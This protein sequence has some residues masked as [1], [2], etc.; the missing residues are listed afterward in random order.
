MARSS[1]GRPTDRPYLHIP[2]PGLTRQSSTLSHLPCTRTRAHVRRYHQGLDLTPADFEWATRQML[3]VASICCPGRLVSTLEGGYGAYE[4]S[5]DSA[6]GWAVSR[7]QLAENVA[8]H[9]SALAGINC[10]AT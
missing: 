3:A 5:K 9:L 2:S 8:A 10:F 6:T 1:T 7:S 4:F